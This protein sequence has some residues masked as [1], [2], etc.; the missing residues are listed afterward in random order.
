MKEET[1]EKYFSEPYGDIYSDSKKI[2]D[3]SSREIPIV[4][5]KGKIKE[6]LS[7]CIFPSWWSEH[8]ANTVATKYFRRKEVPVEGGR[9]TDIRQLISRVAKTTTKWGVEQNYFNE[10]TAEIFEQELAALTIGQYGSFNSPVWFNVGLDSYGIF[11][12][13]DGFY[14]KDNKIVKLENYYSHPQ[15][16]A[17]F[18][19][20]PKDS[21]EDMTKLGAVISSRIFK[22]GSGI[23][24]DWSNVRAAGEPISGGGVSSG[25]LKFAG[26]QDTTG[27]VIKSGGITRRAATNQSLGVWHPDTVDWIRYKY[28]SEMKARVLVDAGSPKNWESHTFQDLKGQ[29]ANNNVRTDA[30]FW[31][32]YENNENYDL[33]RVTDGKVTASIPA[34]KLAKWL[35]FANHQC[36]DPNVQYHDIINKW[37]TCKNSGT[38]WAT[39]PCSE[40]NFLDE[41]ACN[42]ASL[43]LL[44]FR[45][46]EGKFDLDS[47]FKAVDRYIIAQDIFV[48][49]FSYPTE[50][51]AWNS[52]IFRPLGLG[53]ANLGAYIMSLGLP[54]DSDES[55]DFS[56]AITSAMT[57]E[58]YLQS[59]KLAEQ[60]GPFQEFEKNKEPML[61]VLEMH[62]KAAKQIP[63]KNGLEAIVKKTEKIWKEVIE[64]GKEYGF[65]NAQVT[66]LA[67][68]GTIGFMMGCDTTGCE[69]EFQ[70]KKYKELAGGGSMVIV[71][72]T[73]PLALEKLGYDKN[74]IE[75]IKEYIDKN[76]NVEGCEIL[77]P[78]HLPVFDCAVV[79]GKATRSI[80]PMGHIKM[81]GAIQ[82][83]LSGAISKTINC[84][85][86]TTVEEIEDMFYQSWKLGVKAVAIY[87][88]GCKVAQPLS[89]K[90]D[91]KL[92]NIT[93][94]EIEPLPNPRIGITEKV[95]IGG[96]SYFIRTGEYNDGRLGEIFL[97]SLQR[98]TDVNRLINIF[99][100]QFSKELQL[101]LPLKEALEMLEKAG[102]SQIAGVTNHP[103]IKMV[104]SQEEFLRKWISAHYLGEISFVPKEPEMRP[105]PEE[106]RVYQK[107]PKLHMLPTV[108]GEIMYPGVPSLED[109]IKKISGTNFWCDSENG[110]DTRETI[111]KIKN[112]RV[113]GKE[114]L[115]PQ[116]ISGKLTGKTCPVCGTMMVSDGSCS[117]C[118]HC[119]TST[120]GCGGG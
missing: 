59:A 11:Q 6:K 54:Y 27:G 57:A 117:K 3:Y 91:S 67:P 80:E 4:D 20:S 30:E 12:E 58:A 50:E 82:P 13:R 56:A 109:T 40:F 22:G 2:I 102:Q 96:V 64:K 97:D 118:P 14:V 43:N 41:S 104:S 86:T 69:P 98:G 31:R 19:L 68:T 103:F 5:D 16:S 48:S 37:N 61:E 105:L 10:A 65:R 35:S 88:D 114:N 94:G 45:M 55:R 84:P 32:A 38:I 17:C 71:N 47:F 95:K 60:L 9:E 29:N 49:E 81:L 113:W 74:K 28:I 34:R 8:A 87:R 107:I 78:E 106:L 73:V 99:A 44:R 111:E 93:R 52:H 112:T 39:N 79:S 23:G 42:L 92:I 115:N 24:G 76:D 110:L 26:I 51:I 18:I 36:G 83:H 108:D 21:I 72:E 100:M 90:K 46:P 25:F 66:L 15:G 116:K 62:Q 63:K 77:N 7:N 75:Q 53:Y 33:R 119:K 101:G 89:T 70:L 1:I 120:G 85:E